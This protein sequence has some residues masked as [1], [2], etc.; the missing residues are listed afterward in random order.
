[1]AVGLVDGAIVVIDLVLG[2]EKFFLEKHPAAITTMSFFE[3]KVL[4]SGSVDGRVNISDLENLKKK[5]MGLNYNKIRFS[6]CQ[7]CQNRKIPIAKVDT[8]RDFGIGMAVDI[9]GNC[10]FYDLIR[11]KKMAKLNP[12]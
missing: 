12:I 5:K 1:L 2:L 8:C 4:I 9:E 10:R 7:N 6:K 11:F 3:D